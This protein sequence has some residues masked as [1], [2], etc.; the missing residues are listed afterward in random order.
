MAKKFYP[1]K[2]QP[3]YSVLLMISALWMIGGFLT[4]LPNGAASKPNILGYFSLC[5]F[6]PAAT[7]FCFAGAAVT[8]LLRA[9]LFKTDSAGER[10]PFSRHLFALAVII[11]LLAVAG[12]ATGI[13]AA[14][15]SRFTSAI[16]TDISAPAPDRLRDG[17][18]TGTWQ[19]DEVEA[20][21]ELTVSAGRITGGRLLS[22]KNVPENVFTEM[23]DGLTATQS[24]EIDAVTGATASSS[25]VLKA[26]E[27]ALLKSSGQ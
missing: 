6:A 3:W 22:G 13:W 27:Q 24:L 9:L 11:P 20:T 8:C 2:K 5:T 16:V 21:V 7:L 17:S 14:D 4:L 15:A 26:C 18:F 25:V 19:S 1:V 10:A 12:V 23:I